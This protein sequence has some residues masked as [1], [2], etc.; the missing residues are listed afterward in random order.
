MNSKKVNSEGGSETDDDKSKTEGEIQQED[1][2]SNIRPLYA[3]F[4][5]PLFIVCTGVLIAYLKRYLQARMLNLVRLVDAYMTP[6][7]DYDPDQ[8]PPKVIEMLDAME[9]DGGDSISD[10]VWDDSIERNAQLLVDDIRNPNAS[11]SRESS[12]INVN[13]DDYLNM[14]QNHD[15]SDISSS[16]L[17]KLISIHFVHPYH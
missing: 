9:T 16:T 3:L 7:D 5:L 15:Q 12:I 6:S 4:I 13:L 10:L 11:N 1:Q 2:N 8:T 14:F 17:R